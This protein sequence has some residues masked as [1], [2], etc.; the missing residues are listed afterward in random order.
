MI[1]TAWNNRLDPTAADRATQPGARGM[2]GNRR[3][4]L[5]LTAVAMLALPVML[6]AQQTGSVRGRVV[7]ASTNQPKEAVQI[8]IAGTQLG[9]LTG[10]DGT[11]RIDGVSPGAHEVRAT[12]IGFSSVTMAVTVAAGQV[13]TVDFEL[14]PTVLDLEEI[15]ITGVAGQQ[16]RALLPFSVD[17]LTPAALPV[18][19]ANAASMIQGKV[20]GVRVAAAT[21]RPGAAPSVL[22]RGATSINASGRSQEPLYIVD[23]VILSSSI[24]DID[25][26][27]IE[28][29]EIVKGAAAA[30]LYGSRAA[31]GVIQITTQRG[32]HVANDQ[33]RYTLRTEIGASDLPGR[34]NL[35]QKHQFAMTGDGMFIDQQGRPC[36]WIRCPSISLAGQRALPGEAVSAWNSI[37][38]ESWPGVTYD[39]VERFFRGGDYMTNSL[40]VAGRSGGTNYLVAFNRRDDEGIMPGHKGFLQNNFRVNVDQAV[41]E[42]ITVSATAFY[43]RSR[44]SA[45]EGAMFQL[46]R[47]PAGVDLTGPDPNDPDNIILKPDPFNDNANPLYSMLNQTS[48]QQR[49]RFLGS[50]NARWN[51]TSWFGLDGNFSFDRLDLRSENF[52]P[53]GF[54]T[55]STPTGTGGSLG[56]TNSRTEGINASLTA[57]FRRNFGDLTTN[58]QL[59]YLIEKEDFTSTNASGSEFTVDGVWTLDNIP[60]DRQS[61]GSDIQ[62]ERADGYFII[63]DLVYKDRYVVNAL[64]RNDGSSL[65]G[66]DER[67]HWY[68]RGALAWRLSEEPWFNLPGIDE[69][70]LRYS[71]GTAGNRPNFAAQYESYSVSGGSITPQTLGN[72]NLKPEFVV[73]QEMGLDALFLGRFSLDV[74][75]ALTDAQDQ[76]LS[77][78]SLAY[79]GFSSQWQNAGRLESKTFEA[80]LNAQIVRSGDFTWNARLLFDRTRSKITE[81]NVPAY[82]TGVG[83]Q[84]LG[85]VFLMKKG[86]EYGTFYGFQF[87]ENC[88]HLPEGVD[89]SEFQVNDDGFLVWVGGAGSWRNGWQTHTDAD[90][91]T[92]NW[93]GT[94]A[95]FTIRGQAL[96][97]G[98]PFQGEGNDPLTGERTT[99][100]P[101][102]SALP[103][104][105]ISLAN[106]FAYKGLSVYGMFESSQG[107][108][109]Y[110]QPLQWATFQSYSGIMDQ[111]GVAEELQKPTGY[112]DRLYGASGLQ[113]SSAFID[114]ASYIK[115]RELSVR[116][117]L[118]R[119]VLDR[120][121]LARSTSGIA[122]SLVG[123]NL[124]TWTDYDG[125]DPDVGSTGG[126]VG[127]AVIA[128]VDGYSY[129][130]FR[131]LTFGFELI[132]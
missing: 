56:H 108:H 104:F 16:T 23:G 57:Q 32:K 13:A 31:N 122:M 105:N 4:T 115:L 65:F 87:A 18:P 67:R 72:R 45:N 37:Q 88:G 43:S 91:N 49:G 34:F 41:R 82:Q 39:H 93:W 48:E 107:F 121:P 126:G 132:F 130:N 59:R 11:Y 101:L 40:S 17:R 52:T 129:P 9:T 19:A 29:I 33:V 77:V 124:L 69:F 128:R 102:G 106:T 70:K 14:R 63:S 8:S 90:G 53:K 74:T 5:A 68:Y 114:D 85:S 26:M 15:V 95:P 42:D 6:Q 71:Y 100:L 54:R 64:A 62:L 2:N 75:Y 12:F 78:P 92:R 120:I 110:N 81:L 86:V 117:S 83:G 1:D 3:W 22:L 79:T 94:T 89:C 125:Y 131:T 76:I 30:S 84:G 98:T 25:A 97:W 73:E 47:M 111:S 46:T 51:P 58:T 21:G 36:E 20:A 99:F 28:S 109:V 103:D 27:D 66:P 123:R 119:S 10:D 113:P 118:P 44:Q 60:S 80:G 35:T 50:V 96:T 127:S 55:L 38:R 116:Y 112:Y 7:D 61:A 24:V